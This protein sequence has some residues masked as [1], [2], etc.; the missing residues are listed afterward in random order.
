MY[1]VTV[2]VGTTSNALFMEIIPGP[3]IDSHVLYVSR[4][5]NDIGMVLVDT[6]SLSSGA[7]LKTCT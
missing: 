4:L 7:R 6:I 5:L 2:N 1:L 3:T